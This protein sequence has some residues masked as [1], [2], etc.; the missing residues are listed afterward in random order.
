VS[1]FDQ[2]G[3]S[4]SRSGHLSSSKLRSRF[5]ESAYLC[6]ASR[7]ST[8]P[9][10]S[11]FLRYLWPVDF[12]CQAIIRVESYPAPLSQFRPRHTHPDMS[13]RP[14]SAFPPRSLQSQL[15]I[16]HGCLGSSNSRRTFL[17]LLGLP[18]CPVICSSA[19]PPLRATF[20]AVPRKPQSS[21]II[22]PNRT[23]WFFQHYWCD[24]S[25]FFP[26]LFFHY[27]FRRY[28]YYQSPPFDGQAPVQSYGTFPFLLFTAILT[29]RFI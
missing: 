20:L 1:L 11:P 22:F 6:S 18:P 15:F 21:S 10:L 7:F 24:R 19:K 12:S 3:L 29:H 23:H 4:I 9:F 26:D 8:P 25:G 2:E 27:P 5:S 13:V 17:S 14:D 28:S 16:P